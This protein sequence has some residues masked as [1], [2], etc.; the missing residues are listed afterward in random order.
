MTITMFGIDIAK[1]VFH[2][3][4]INHLG[5]QVKKNKL[6]RNQLLQ[7]LAQVPVCKIAMEVCGSSHHWARE[8]QQLGHEVSQ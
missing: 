8:I 1:S 4:A 7:F 5:R 2:L 3:C 6:R